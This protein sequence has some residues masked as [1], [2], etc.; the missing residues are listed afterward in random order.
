MM[1]SGWG[2]KHF[3]RNK[4]KGFFLKIYVN[5]VLLSLGLLITLSG[6]F[7]AAFRSHSLN[8]LFDFNTALLEE[9]SEHVEQINL[10]T[11][12]YVKS[13]FQHLSA[14]RL[15][16]TRSGELNELIRDIKAIERVL[17]SNPYVHSICIY[18][19]EIDTYYLFG[20]K[21]TLIRKGVPHDEG[22]VALLKDGDAAANHPIPRLMP[23]SE[24]RPDALVPVYSY[25]LKGERESETR[26]PYGVV[27]NIDTRIL[28]REP[29]ISGNRVF[30]PGNTYSV[31]MAGMVSGSQDTLDFL[32]PV[33]DREYVR[34]ALDARTRSGYFIADAQG[35]KKLVTYVRSA[36]L[37]WTF[38]NETSYE[39]V[40][41]VLQHIIMISIGLFGLILVGAAIAAYFLSNALYA[42]V[43]R[44]KSVL[45]KHEFSDNS[46]YRHIREF[47]SIADSY[48]TVY[49]E[50]D[51]LESY[52]RTSRQ[53]EKNRILYNL[54]RNGDFGNTQAHELFG[55]HGIALDPGKPAILF[56]LK[57]DRY[58]REY[59]ER[60][61]QEDREL[62]KFA[63]NNMTRE[64]VAS[65]FPLCE[66]VDSG[67]DCTT[68]IISLERACADDASLVAH[69]E[70]CIRSV[71]H[72]YSKFAGIGLSA[73][74]SDMAENLYAIGEAYHETL[75]LSRQRLVHGHGCI[76]AMEGREDQDAATDVYK[77][78]SIEAMLDAIKS[79]SCEKAEAA[80]RH[81]VQS[82]RATNYRTVVY[83]VL[84]LNSLIMNTLV[85]ME[86]NMGVEFGIDF[87]AVNEQLVRCETIEEI[88]REFH[89]VFM[90][91]GHE[92][93]GLRSDKNSRSIRQINDY[94]EAS[95]MFDT[96]SSADIAEKFG[97]A[98][99]YVNRI[100]R[101]HAGMSITNRI[102]QVRLEKAALLLRE[103]DD[104]IEKI[105]ES[106][107]WATKE[108]FYS[109]FKKTYGVT[110]G[111]YRHGAGL[112]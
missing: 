56:I 61:N 48:E 54:L 12:F 34:K 80:C 107:G 22:V 4:E 29:Q 55:A 15:M 3:G 53:H 81:I 79:G 25:L 74:I 50:R 37:K 28:F 91:I 43:H 1:C 38:I 5:I 59:L 101:R 47:K 8:Q 33:G 77:G 73:F 46:D 87:V 110:P 17:A 45:Q 18:N 26:L 103:T 75:A 68:T 76:L 11:T 65:R 90:D 72:E 85:M 84:Y 83:T 19:P 93:D 95:Y 82:V 14:Q 88:D 51:G 44:L 98:Q 112:R 69:L 60:Y 27:V 105:L 6:F 10:N 108:Y 58:E 92:L 102:K 13:V 97:L 100:Y 109:T 66:A 16:Y 21:D 36:A 7:Y 96:L 67:E 94:I 106:V 64:I 41:V 62:Y 86:K 52:R 32:E 89:Q 71:Q 23:D 31:D 63:L 30:V 70:S 78:E 40:T 20:E 9:T 2:M 42:P 49:R 57:I 35:S 39:N 111:D 99:S 24:S 104:A